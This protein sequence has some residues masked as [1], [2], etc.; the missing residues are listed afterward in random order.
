MRPTLIAHN[1]AS[2][3]RRKKAE[4]AAKEK[5]KNK[6]NLEEAL[7]A[8]NPEAASHLDDDPAQE[9]VKSRK[10]SEDDDEG[11]EDSPVRGSRKRE[12]TRKTGG[13]D[14][15]GTFDDAPRERSGQR[16]NISHKKR[17]GRSPDRSRSENE[18]ESPPIQTSLTTLLMNRRCHGWRDG[19]VSNITGQKASSFP[20]LS[21]FTC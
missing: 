13:Q 7:A 16:Q 19:D 14:Q 1:E 20:C 18:S 4:Q 17:R 11:E 21:S 9:D 3:S 15:T 5:K 2:T 8:Q 12:R 10:R 6:K